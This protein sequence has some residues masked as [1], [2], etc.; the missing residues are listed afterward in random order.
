MNEKNSEGGAPKKL[1]ILHNEA[2]A[3]GMESLFE[4]A[5]IDFVIL[6]RQD[7]AGPG[8][9]DRD[10]PWGVARVAKADFDRAEGLWKEWLAAEPPDIGDDW[11]RASV[12]VRGSGA[13]GWLYVVLGL[14]ASVILV[15]LFRAYV[16][17]VLP[18]WLPF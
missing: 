18:S 1:C 8:V 9:F 13:K 10:S 2:Q 14:I 12:S 5:G 11:Q 7:T 4:E 17:P 15:Y 3:L 16:R 6:K